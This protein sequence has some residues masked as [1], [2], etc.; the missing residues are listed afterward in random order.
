LRKYI[1]KPSQ[2]PFLDDNFKH[3]SPS[4]KLPTS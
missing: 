3:K 1:Q 2:E 4:R